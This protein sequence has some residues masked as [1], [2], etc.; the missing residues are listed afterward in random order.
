MARRNKKNS[1][2]PIKESLLRKSISAKKDMFGRSLSLSALILI[3][4]VVFSIFS[5][6]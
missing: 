5:L 3:G 1:Q 4:V 6:F 2:D